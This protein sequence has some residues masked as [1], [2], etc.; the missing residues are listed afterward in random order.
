MSPVLLLSENPEVADVSIMAAVE[1]LAARSKRPIYYASGAGRDARH[2]ID[3]PMISMWVEVE[4]ARR[5]AS[6][7]ERR[8]HGLHPSG[9]ELLRFPTKVFDFL[10]KKQIPAQYETEIEDFLKSVTG[11]YRVHIFDH[12]VRASDPGL[13]G[14]KQVREPASLVHN[15]Y[16]SKSGFVCLQE[17]LGEDAEALARDRFQILNIWRPLVDPVQ[18]YPLALCDARTFTQSD[19]VDTERR[20]PSHVGEIQLAL[21]SPQQRWYYYSEMRPDEVLLFKTFDSIDGGIN[22]CSTHTAIRLPDA[23]ADAKPRESIES[24]ALVFYR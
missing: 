10:V 6:D 24:R 5:R 22:P 4:D 12:T 11:C 21:H 8:E 23:P 20:S 1:Y 9:F 2:E 13:R 19:L 3:Q 18:D 17:N 15:D 16:T 7:D 14:L